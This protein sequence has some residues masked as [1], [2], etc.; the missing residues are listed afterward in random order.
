MEDWAPLKP[1]LSIVVMISTLFALV[2]LQMEE[3]RIGYEILKLN[4]EQKHLIE[5]RRLK[6]MH[7]A[8]VTR[9][10]QMEKLAVSRLTL[11]KIQASQIIHLSGPQPIFKSEPERRKIN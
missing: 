8:K 1:F 6:E 11:R 4:H 10:Q 5:D 7:L 2:F 3:R 9:P